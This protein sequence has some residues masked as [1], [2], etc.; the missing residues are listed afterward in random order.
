MNLEACYRLAPDVAI[1]PERFG[2]LVYRHANRRLYF[3]HSRELVDLVG[4]LDGTRP[5]TVHLDAFLTT[6]G[7]P[8]TA[9]EAFV[10][11]LGQLAELAVLDEVADV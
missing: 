6:H 5:L 9:R 8:E 4:T 10:A 3:L 11:A 7:L 1:R 2:G